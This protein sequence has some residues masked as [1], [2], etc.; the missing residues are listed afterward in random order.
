MTAVQGRPFTVTAS[1]GTLN[2]PGNAQ[3]ADQVKPS[4]NKIGSPEEFYD[5]SA[6]VPH[7]GTPHFGNTGRDLPRGPGLVNASLSV[8]RDFTLT[9]R[10]QLQFRAESFNLMNHPNLGVPNTAI[11]NARVGTITTTIN[12]ERQNQFALKLYF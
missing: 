10:F 12:P 2:A 9:E 3:T 4:A 5:K 8:F 6:F 11:G 7:T 1:A